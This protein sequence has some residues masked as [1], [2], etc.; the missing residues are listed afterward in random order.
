MSEDASTTPYL[1][2]RYADLEALRAENATL[3]T[4]VGQLLQRVQVLEA[5]LAKDGQNSRG[6]RRGKGEAKRPGLI[7]FQSAD[8]RLTLPLPPHTNS[9]SRAGLGRL[10]P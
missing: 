6:Q 8:G 3:W 2:L 7:G 1:D 4:Q 9:F 5:R 10:P